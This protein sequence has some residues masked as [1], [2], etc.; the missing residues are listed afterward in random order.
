MTL[1][2]KSHDPVENSRWVTWEE[3][4]RR[5]DRVVE[6]RMNIVFVVLGVILL[7]LLLH[8]LRQVGK[9]TNL[10]EK[11]STVAC[12][13]RTDPMRYCLECWKSFKPA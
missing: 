13:W 1:S 5:Q 9:R 10:V 3:K 12:Q 6:K 4:S 2:E 8:G 11:A 7:V